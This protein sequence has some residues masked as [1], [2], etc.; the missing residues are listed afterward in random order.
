[1]FN[2][3]Y[4]HFSYIYRFSWWLTTLGQ[5]KINS[6]Q[7]CSQGTA[8]GPKAADFQA[9]LPGE[10]WLDI[11]PEIDHFTSRFCVDSVCVCKYTMCNIYIY[12]YIYV[13]IF[14]Y[15]YSHSMC[16]YGTSVYVCVLYICRPC[17]ALATA[18]WRL[19]PHWVWNLA[20]LADDCIY[21]AGH[22]WANAAG[23]AFQSFLYRKVI[24]PRPTLL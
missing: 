5:L 4:A 14:I 3:S 17:L 11:T 22:G 24:S 2:V 16:I 13:Y 20:C 1:M 6:L 18:G 15:I 8:K 9:T 10:K 12:I 19:G 23:K 21:N 7:L